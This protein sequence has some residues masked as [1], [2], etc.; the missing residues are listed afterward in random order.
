MLGFDWFVD[1]LLNGT[2]DSRSVAP[3]DARPVAL[4][5]ALPWIVGPFPVRVEAGVAVVLLIGE[6]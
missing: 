4:F 2:G 6:V 5:K 3:P 1:L